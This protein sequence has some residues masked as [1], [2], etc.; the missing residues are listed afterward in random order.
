[1]L[2]ITMDTK[3]LYPHDTGICLDYVNSKM[4]ELFCNFVLAVF[5]TSQPISASINPNIRLNK[6]EIYNY[7]C[8]YYYCKANCSV[9]LVCLQNR[10][11]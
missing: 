11:F 7:T 4:Y 8:T 9:L 6:L 3:I 2:C 10:M 1:M 5:I